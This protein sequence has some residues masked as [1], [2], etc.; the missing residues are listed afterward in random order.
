M[1]HI[2]LA[3]GS[4]VLTPEDV[5]RLRTLIEEWEDASTALL[6]LGGEIKEMIGSANS[7]RKPMVR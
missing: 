4:V 2:K 7:D 6:D 3:P 1:E 5:S